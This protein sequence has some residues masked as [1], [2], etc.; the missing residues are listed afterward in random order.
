MPPLV[1]VKLSETLKKQR[2]LPACFST[3]EL[4]KPEIRI[5]ASELNKY[6]ALDKNA[7]TSILSSTKEINT[8]SNAEL[9]RGLN[10]VNHVK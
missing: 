8:I 2:Y 3:L 7:L 9:T 5:L 10:K 4:N 1:I 6:V